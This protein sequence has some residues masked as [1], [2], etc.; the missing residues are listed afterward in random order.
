MLLSKIQTSLYLDKTSSYDTFVNLQLVFNNSH[1]QLLP[2]HIHS[3][4]TTL[5][6]SLSYQF[7]FLSFIPTFHLIIKAPKFTS[8]NQPILLKRRIS[9]IHGHIQGSWNF[10]TFTLQNVSAGL[11]HFDLCAF[12]HRIISGIIQ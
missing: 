6:H 8:S 10:T 2:Q 3:T 9:C 12:N 11:L 4:Y 1:S 5:F 7:S